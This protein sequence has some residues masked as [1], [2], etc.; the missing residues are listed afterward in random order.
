MADDRWRQAPASGKV[1][2]RQ[3]HPHGGREG[4][5]PES[6]A[7]MDQ[8]ECQARDEHLHGGPHLDAPE[9]TQHEAAEDDLLDHRPGYAHRGP[10]ELER[11]EFAEILPDV[12]VTESNRRVE[13]PENGTACDSW[14]GR[15]SPPS[16]VGER[17]ALAPEPGE[18]HPQRD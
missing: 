1:D 3:D 9:L 17:T 18:D 7:E 12:R 16:Q 15:R 10:P 5:P 4:D 14:P 6:E 11:A 2:N 8:P 13:E